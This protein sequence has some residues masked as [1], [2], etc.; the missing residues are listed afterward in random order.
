MRKELF[1]TFQSHL[2]FAN[3]STFN[4]LSN[5]VLSSKQSNYAR[6]GY[7]KIVYG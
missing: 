2:N 4:S 3:K 5:Q 7:N 1:L 6:I